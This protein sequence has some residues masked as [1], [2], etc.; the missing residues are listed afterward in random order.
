M[1]QEIRDLGD[2]PYYGNAVL[3]S[4]A[5][6]SPTCWQGT[7]EDALLVVN[8]LGPPYRRC[9]QRHIKSST[10]L[11]GTTVTSKSSSHSADSSKIGASLSAVK[12]AIT[13]GCGVCS[14]YSPT[15]SKPSMRPLVGALPICGPCILRARKV[16]RLTEVPSF[17]VNSAK[18][19]TELTRSFASLY[20]AKYCTGSEEPKMV[21][22][23]SNILRVPESWP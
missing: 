23:D 14:Q 17:S 12:I 10:L 6:L 15:S 22:S 20:D 13:L 3:L 8:G 19:N 9:W 2:F 18:N 21:R 1:L 11:A 5:C 16:S 4:V 7:A